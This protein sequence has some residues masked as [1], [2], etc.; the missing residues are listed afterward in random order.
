MLLS[1]RLKQLNPVLDFPLCSDK[2]SYL[3]LVYKAWWVVHDAFFVF[4]SGK[5]YQIFQFLLHMFSLLVII[6]LMFSWAC[7]FLP[8]GT[9]H[10]LVTH[11]LNIFVL[12][13]PCAEP[14][15]QHEST[16]Q[17]FG[18]VMISRWWSPCEW[19]VS[20]QKKFSCQA[21]TRRRCHV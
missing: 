18:V 19:I 6:S 4:C 13:D 17:G 9:L 2:N 8:L 11:I 3:E 15:S 21:K 1:K 20:L 14:N 5:H 10:P 12:L 7:E 16:K